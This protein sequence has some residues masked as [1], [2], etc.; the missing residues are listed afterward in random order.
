MSNN[1]NVFFSE[2]KC[3]KTRN[4]IKTWFE[5]KQTWLWNILKKIKLNHRYNK[6]K[7]LSV[8]KPWN[9]T[10]L[11]SPWT[12]RPGK[13]SFHYQCL[14][15][16]D[17]QG[18]H[19]TDSEGQRLPKALQKSVVRHKTYINHDDSKPTIKLNLQIIMSI[20]LIE[21]LDWNQTLCV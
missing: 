10:F 17:C 6:K 12:C 16:E 5:D 19:S 8:S 18:D 13:S 4:K 20:T 7:W 11:S 1:F 2:H 15:G 14:W 21:S 3:N 9:P